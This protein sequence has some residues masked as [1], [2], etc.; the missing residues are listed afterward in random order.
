MVERL[1]QVARFG[2]CKSIACATP[3]APRRYAHVG[4][5]SYGVF[6]NES[7][8]MISDLDRRGCHQAAEQCL[9]TLLDFQGTVPLP[10]NFKI[11]R[12]VVLRG[13]GAKRASATTN[14]TAT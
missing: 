2:I 3:V 6:A 4:T 11:D 14:T 5:F 8:M 12:G 1:L 7:A 9:Q 13:R 10:G